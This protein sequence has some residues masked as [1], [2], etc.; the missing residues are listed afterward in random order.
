MFFFKY[1]YISSIQ[2]SQ[3]RKLENKK[4][5]RYTTINVA[6]SV[7]ICYHPVSLLRPSS[8]LFYCSKNK[9]LKSER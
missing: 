9:K 8:I 2:A 1:G 7:Q 4:R 6:K 3:E 5:K